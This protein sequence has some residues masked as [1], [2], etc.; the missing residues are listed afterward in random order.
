MTP[1]CKYNKFVKCERPK[2]CDACGFNPVVGHER[3]NIFRRSIGVKE[4]EFRNV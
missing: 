4:K 1:S 2:G 3:I